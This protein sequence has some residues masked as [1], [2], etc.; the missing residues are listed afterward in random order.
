MASDITLSFG[1][2]S[3]TLDY[4]DP[5]TIYPSRIKNMTEHVLENGDITIDQAENFKR[6]WN[7]LIEVPLLQADRDKLK[8]LYENNNAITL[9]ENWVDPGTYSVW[10]KN[11]QPKFVNQSGNTRLQ[12]TLQEV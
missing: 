11:Y 1:A 12:L 10:F 7:L 3:I 6:S 5:T 4:V 9:V 2:T 8:T